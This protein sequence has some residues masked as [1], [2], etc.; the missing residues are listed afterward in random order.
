MKPYFVV[1]PD[2]E[3]ELP[4]LVVVE[5]I[6]KVVDRDTYRCK[7]LDMPW[8]PSPWREV[9]LKLAGLDEPG[10][11]RGKIRAQAVRCYV[12]RHLE[13]ADNIALRSFRR[14]ASN[15][16]LADVHADFC[17]LAEFLAEALESLSPL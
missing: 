13:N 17:N 5:K 11:V 1:T 4:R 6:V 12:A 2:V 15:R 3:G 10:D 9:E 7:I 8:C 14:S 16:I